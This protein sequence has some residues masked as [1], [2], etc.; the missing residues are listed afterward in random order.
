[1]LPLLRL[2]K[3]QFTQAQNAARRAA[4]ISNA[5]QL[6]LGV[7]MY[8]QDNNE[9][10]PA[11]GSSFQ[12]LIM[13]YVKNE[14]LFSGFVYEHS[15]GPLSAISDPS[16]TRL[17]YVPGPGGRAILYADGHVIWEPDP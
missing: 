10:L 12:D 7:M 15:G 6:G 16:K 9:I 1:V 14:S 13:P 11:P 2:P 5:K 4:L 3:E 8:A 17:G